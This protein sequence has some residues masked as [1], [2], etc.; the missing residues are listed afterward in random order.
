[1]SETTITRADLAE[2]VYQEVGLSRNE[3]AQL[4]ETVL[5]EISTALI[6]DEVVKISSFGSFSVRQKG[7][8]IG[9]NPKTGEEVPILPR[10]VLVFR[11]SQVLKA[12]I[13]A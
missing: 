2:A 4:L 13:N 9:R 3:S 5:D 12:R 1:M 7:Q 11:P 8:R 6:K 10:K